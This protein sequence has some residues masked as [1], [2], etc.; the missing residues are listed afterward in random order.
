MK[1][2][3]V[4]YSIFISLKLFCICQ[5]TVLIDNSM[6]QCKLKLC[7]TMFKFNVYVVKKY[8]VIFLHK[9]WLI[10]SYKK[11]NT[12]YLTRLIFAHFALINSLAYVCINL[13]HCKDVFH[14][15][16]MQYTEYFWYCVDAFSKQNRFS[17]IKKSL[18]KISSITSFVFT[19][20]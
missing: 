9:F 8:R 1:P 16:N 20:K 7:F 18:K 13:L 6:I 4:I 10:L 3:T 17:N 19:Y 14:F 2:A 15:C 5:Q 12:I 11:L